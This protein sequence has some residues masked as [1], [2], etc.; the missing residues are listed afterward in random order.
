[1]DGLAA[2]LNAP[3]LTHLGIGSGSY[4][5]EGVGRDSVR[6]RHAVSFM[7]EV[8][9]LPRLQALDLY[10][11][12]FCEA[13][14][15]PAHAPSSSG[16]SPCRE[17]TLWLARDNDESTAGLIAEALDEL[18]TLYPKLESLNTGL[19]SDEELRQVVR[20]EGLTSLS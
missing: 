5:P 6:R 11:P 12:T 13:A 15:V 7:G 18:P 9:A 20:L 4:F 17:M 19:L 3:Q 1:G 2:L 10:V 8:A 16:P 14:V